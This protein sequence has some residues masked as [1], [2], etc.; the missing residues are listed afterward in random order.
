MKETQE[1][2]CFSPNKP[3]NVCLSVNAYKEDREERGDVFSPL[4]TTPFILYSVP[5][6]MMA[7]AES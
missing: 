6:I 4:I 2:I 3:Q 5:E 7:S 1:G